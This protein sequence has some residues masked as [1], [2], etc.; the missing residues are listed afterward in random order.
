[1]AS[2]AFTPIASPRF[3][4]VWHRTVR[5]MAVR[6]QAKPILVDVPVSN[7]GARVRF[8]L[9]KKGLAE[10][11]DIK[12]PADFGGLKSSTYLELNAQGKMPLLIQPGGLNLPE[13]E[14]IVQYLLDKWQGQ[15]PSLVAV[16]PDTR[17]QGA[18]ITRIHDLYIAP[19]QGCM[20]R[21]MDDAGVRA[22]QLAQ[23][24]YQL[25]VIENTITGKPF[26]CGEHVTTA[27]GALF[28]TMVFLLHMLP[29][30]GWSDLFS[31]RPKLGA[32]WRA[33]QQD[34]EA[35]KVIG[36]VQGGLDSWEAQG[37]WRDILDQVQRHPEL[38]WA[39]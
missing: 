16:S 2:V 38:K 32:W 3:P 20:Y 5:R 7:H 9:Y 29:K 12:S 4:T 31:S 11:Y 35:C 34:S 36:E 24:A 39:H 25:D 23:I 27:D 1:M 26:I 30:F 21:A 33:V 14:V 13:S 8:V 6:A 18:L 22:A 17:A 15:G 19:V 37:R 10:Q 28:P